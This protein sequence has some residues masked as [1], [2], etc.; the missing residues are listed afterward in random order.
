MIEMIDAIRDPVQRWYA[1]L[2]GF[3]G[4]VTLGIGGL[5]QQ[6]GIPLLSALLL[7]LIG[8]AAP[9]QLTQSV[10]MLA[11]LGPAGTGSSRWRAALAYVGGKALVYS[12]LG[13]VAVVAGAGLSE[14]SIPVFVG[15]R[16]ALGPLMVIVGLA[17]AGALRLHWAPGAG[18]ARRLRDVVQRRAGRAPFLMGVVFGFSFCPTLFALYFAFLIPLALARPEGVLYPTLFALG[19]ALPLLLVVALLSLGGGGSARRY[20]RQI[21]RGQRVIAVVAGVLLVIVGLHDTVVYWLL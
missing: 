5:N 10:G 20:A 15:A 7:G 3:S 2:S 4:D 6:L 19:T 18:L 17:V 11:F 8:A 1:F 14:V 13:V 12:A 9:C 21:G 16:K